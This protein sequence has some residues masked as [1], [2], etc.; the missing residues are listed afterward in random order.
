MVGGTVVGASVGVG[1][2]GVALGGIG[3]GA[4]VFVAVAR[5]A[6]AGGGNVTVAGAVGE[7]AATAVGGKLGSAVAATVGMTRSGGLSPPQ[8]LNSAMNRLKARTKGKDNDLMDI[9]PLRDRRRGPRRG[10]ETIRN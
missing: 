2:G 6:V 7:M 4:G 3:V 10:S 5:M 8:A 1:G 9:I